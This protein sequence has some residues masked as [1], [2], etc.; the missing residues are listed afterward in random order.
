MF[1]IPLLLSI[2]SSYTVLIPPRKLITILDAPSSFSKKHSPLPAI[3]SLSDYG[4]KLGTGKTL[5]PYR[6]SARIVCVPAKSNDADLPATA[7]GGAS[8]TPAPHRTGYPLL[9]PKPPGEAGRPGPKGYKLSTALDMNN[10]KEVHAYIKSL[11]HQYLVTDK[12]ITQQKPVKL[13]QLFHRSLRR[14]PQLDEYQDNWALR[15]FVTTILHN[16]KKTAEAPTTRPR[17]RFQ[18]ERAA[19]LSA[20]SGSAMSSISTSSSRSEHT[21]R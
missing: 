6:T 9:I 4:S 17:V 3:P 18:P 8:R 5:A 15:D 12:P 19:R 10:Y 16:C 7:A 11:V 21:R 2:E 20:S 1:N 14:Y 13:E